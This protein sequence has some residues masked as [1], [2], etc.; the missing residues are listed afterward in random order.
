M[1]NRLQ[2]SYIAVNGM[3]REILTPNQSGQDDDAVVGLDQGTDIFVPYMSLSLF[4]PSPL[5]SAPPQVFWHK[6]Q[7]LLHL[8]LR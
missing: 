8:I 1:Y 6:K 7:I 3:L 5:L 4:S 2:Y